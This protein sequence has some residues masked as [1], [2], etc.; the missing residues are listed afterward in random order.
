MMMFNIRWQRDD[1]AK[2]VRDDTYWWMVTDDIWWMESLVAD[3]SSMV[4]LSGDC[5]PSLL[6]HN[7]ITK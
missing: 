1:L 4:R 5:C 7:N 6:P 3:L 2:M